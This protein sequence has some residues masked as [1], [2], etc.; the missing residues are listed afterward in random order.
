MISF[1]THPVLIFEVKLSLT[2]W[3]LIL[4]VLAVTDGACQI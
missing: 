4:D 2:C 3:N 1:F